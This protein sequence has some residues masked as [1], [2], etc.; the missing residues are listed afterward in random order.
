[1]LFASMLVVK[2]QTP[3]EI[4]TINHRSFVCK[5]AGLLN[6]LAL[7]EITGCGDQ[8]KSSQQKNVRLFSDRGKQYESNRDGAQG[9]FF[10][11]ENGRPR[12]CDTICDDR[13][14]SLR[15]QFDNRRSD[16]VGRCQ[17]ERA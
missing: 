3:R 1:M 10:Q 13:L 16:G 12:P 8:V 7:K 9:T 11:H 6:S 17:S 4:R 14:L 15:P 5:L 2:G